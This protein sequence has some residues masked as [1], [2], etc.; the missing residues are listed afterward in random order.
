MKKFAILFTMACISL[1]VQAQGNKPAKQP[2]DWD[3][4]DKAFIGIVQAL[5]KGDKIAF[6]A[7]SMKEVDCPDCVGSMDR[8]KD[9]VFVPSAFFFAVI[10]KD[11]TKSPVFL[12]MTKKGYSFSSIVVENFKPRVMPRDYPKDLKL[13]EVWVETYKP[14][15]LSPTHTGT[16]HSFRFV[17]VNGKFRFYGLNSIP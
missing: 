11:F 9:G 15:E 2:T 14:G 4:L 16:S 6:Q 5:E 12:A 7:L 1:S 13:Y 10:A 8:D 3:L 17:K